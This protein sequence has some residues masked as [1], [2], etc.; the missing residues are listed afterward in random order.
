MFY[1]ISFDDDTQFPVIQ[2]SI[3]I[4][5][6]LHVQLQYKGSP[7]PLPPFFVKS[8]N[9]KLKRISMLENFPTYMRNLAEEN[10]Y[11]IMDARVKKTTALQTSG[12]PPF[13]AELIIVQVIWEVGIT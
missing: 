11:S 3:K 4:D 7:I 12:R 8:H 5:H 9:A 10:P 13:S 6:N 1:R 2:E